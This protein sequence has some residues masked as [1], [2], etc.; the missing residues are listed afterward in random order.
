MGI[1]MGIS[2]VLHA[3]VETTPI[4][5]DTPDPFSVGLSMKLRILGRQPC[6]TGV[7]DTCTIA[8]SIFCRC[9]VHRLI[10][11]LGTATNI[12]FGLEFTWCGSLVPP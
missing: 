9:F 10:L 5:N 1:S 7:R 4:I 3:Q 12:F 6:T 2:T 8:D 11:V